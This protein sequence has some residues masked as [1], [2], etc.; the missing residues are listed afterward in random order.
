MTP[1]EPLRSIEGVATVERIDGALAD[2]DAPPT[3]LVEVPHGADRRAH[4]DALAARLHGP[5][6]ADLHVFFHVN[7]DV[8]AYDYGR[9]VA[10]AVVRRLP[11]CAALVVRCLVPRTFIDA[12]RLE[13]AGDG[14]ASGGLTPGLAP[15]VRDPRDVALC[16][17]LHRAYVALAEEAYALVCERGGFALNPHTYGPRTMGIERID[18]AIVDA[19]RAAH[20][21]QAWARWPVRPEVDLLTR[22][23]D[24]TSYAPPGMAARLVDA[25]RGVGIEAVEG[26]TYVLHPSTQGYRFATRYP[27][28]TLS[29]EVRRDLLVERYEPFEE[30]RVEHAR[31]ERVAGPLADALVAWLEEALRTP[32]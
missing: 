23:A 31:V 24:G 16:V 14:L 32:P 9:H 27:G 3:L 13:D 15:Y 18:D 29:L 26:G 20:E 2:P 19:L 12:N 10:E 1:A 28:Q 6:P 8:G 30:M 17:G 4:Y 22:T 5:L 21:P 25:Y 7:T 11:A